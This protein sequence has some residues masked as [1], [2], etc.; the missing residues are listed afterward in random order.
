MSAVVLLI[1]SL[2]LAW[3]ARPRTGWSGEQAALFCSALVGSCASTWELLTLAVPAFSST[4]AT[5]LLAS[6]CQYAAFPLLLLV[7]A[8]QGL[9]NTSYVDAELLRWDRVIWGRILLVICVIYVLM[10]RSHNLVL[11]DNALLLLGCFAAIA[12]LI[13]ASK[14]NAKRINVVP[15]LVW[16]GL[17]AFYFAKV[18]P[19]QWLIPLG[20]ANTC[21]MI[22]S[23]SISLRK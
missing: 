18:I 1:A 5:Y 17:M 12:W 10:Q 13:A 23:G 11:L 4:E 9:Q 7:A 15:A 8:V 20:F 19:M 6:L 22:Y 16:I 21:V 2:A 14:G 3:L